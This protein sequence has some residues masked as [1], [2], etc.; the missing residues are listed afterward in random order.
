MSGVAR[1][2]DDRGSV[3]AEV[4]LVAPVLIMLLVFV[5]VVVHRGVDA[6]LRINDAAH[7][8]ARAAS[9]ERT[10]A[11]ANSAAQTAATAALSSAGVTCRAL[12]VETVSGGLSP[13]GTITV[14]VSCTVDFGDA[15]I[16]GVPGRKRL[17]STASQPVDTWR[18]TGGRG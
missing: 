12:Q 1:W 2:R 8:A 6:R 11:S 5:G 10:S 4:T 15:L 16:L 3:A 9:I 7:Q 18:S 14:A 17:S 13:G